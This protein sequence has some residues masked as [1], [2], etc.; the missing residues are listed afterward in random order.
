MRSSTSSAAG[1][2]LYIGNVP[3]HASGNGLSA[4]AWASLADVHAAAVAPSLRVLAEAG[5]PAYAAPAAPS[6]AS[7][8]RD[9]RAHHQLLRLW[10]DAHQ[11]VRARQL[12][13]A[14][15]P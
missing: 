10:V 12:I 8:A 11:T 3:R 9:H 7:T 14:T 4:T 15:T 5:I 1:P 13:A 2:S 6:G